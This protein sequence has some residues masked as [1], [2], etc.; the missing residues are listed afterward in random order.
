M[1]KW[2]VS[3]KDGVVH[4][5]RHSPVVCGKVHLLKKKM[6]SM[7]TG[8]KEMAVVRCRLIRDKDCSCSHEINKSGEGKEEVHRGRKVVE[9]L[10]LIS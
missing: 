2:F 8:K 9:E 3:F 4:W 6:Y 10:N 7:M 1:K 5:S